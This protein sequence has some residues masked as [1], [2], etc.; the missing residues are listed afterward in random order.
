MLLV[1]KEK[2][3]GGVGKRKSKTKSKGK[4]GPKP[5]END[6]K[7]PKPKPQKDGIC[8]HCNKLGHWKRN[9]PLYLEELKK[10]GGGAS[11]SSIFVIEVNLS[12]STSWVLDTGCGSHIVQMY[13]D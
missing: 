6:P 9:Y 4:V 7:A 8:F 11:T 13:K 5:K 10:N 2:G 12:I 1:Q 3:K